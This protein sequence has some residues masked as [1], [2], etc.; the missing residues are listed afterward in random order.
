MAAYVIMSVRR[1]QS[2]YEQETE[3]L[4]LIKIFTGFPLVPQ[5]T[6][7]SMYWPNR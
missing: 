6:I 3:D 4:F 1:Y 7:A 2:W 5:F